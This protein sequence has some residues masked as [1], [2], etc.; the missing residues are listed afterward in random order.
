IT[1][2]VLKKLMRALGAETVPLGDVTGVSGEFAG[3]DGSVLVGV[4]DQIDRGINSVSAA[5]ASLR[6]YA[7]RNR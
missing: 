5:A 4:A 1:V 6:R 3:V 2:A 7:V